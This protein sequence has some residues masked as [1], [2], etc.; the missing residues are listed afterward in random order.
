MALKKHILRAP[1]VLCC[2]ILESQLSPK[3]PPGPVMCMGG[4][5]AK[6]AA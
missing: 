6:R 2:E 3:V 5:R 4:G 1:L